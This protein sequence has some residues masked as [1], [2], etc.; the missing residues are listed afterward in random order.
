MV[1]WSGLMRRNLSCKKYFVSGTAKVWLSICLREASIPNNP[2]CLG[3]ESFL[4]SNDFSCTTFADKWTTNL[5]ALSLDIDPLSMSCCALLWQ[6]DPFV[7]LYKITVP[8][9][10]KSHFSSHSTAAL[11]LPKW[12]SK[13]PSLTWMSGS[14]G[15]N[16]DK[17]QNIQ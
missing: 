14:A 10:R 12:N 9:A 6:P 15:N 3:Y 16:A 8:V 1:C 17:W 4:K 13:Y 7:R 2:P 11:V 5:T